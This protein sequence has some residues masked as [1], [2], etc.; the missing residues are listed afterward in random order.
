MLRT[1]GFF[2]LTFVVVVSLAGCSGSDDRGDIATAQKATEAAPKSDSDLPTS[3]PA[4]ARRGAS[5][6]IAQQQ[7]MQQQ[8]NA[9]AEAMRKARAS[10]Q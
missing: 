7:A 3:M 8:M 9:Q 1:L 6:A 5:A 10:G 2:T 4:E